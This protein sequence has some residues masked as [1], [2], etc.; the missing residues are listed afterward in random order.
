[1]IS[2]PLFQSETESTSEEDLSGLGTGWEHSQMFYYCIPSALSTL[3]FAN[4]LPG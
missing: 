2:S 1:M 3:D 4:S